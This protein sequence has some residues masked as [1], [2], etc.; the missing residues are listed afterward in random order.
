MKE[1]IISDVWSLETLNE[2]LA[3]RHINF[4]YDMAI[5]GNKDA[6]NLLKKCFDDDWQTIKERF[7]T[8]GSVWHVWYMDGVRAF[9]ELS[10]TKN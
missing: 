10:K 8:E 6:Q 2:E 7:E 3:S 5:S 4:I 9:M 1:E